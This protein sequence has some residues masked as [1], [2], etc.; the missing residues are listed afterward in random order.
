MTTNK[1]YMVVKDINPTEEIWFE[2]GWILKGVKEKNEDGFI[3]VTN[4][5]ERWYCE[6]LLHESY[7][8]E[9]TENDYQSLY[10]INCDGWDESA[11]NIYQ[12]LTNKYFEL[13]LNKEPL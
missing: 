4:E 5:L 9:M 6:D 8:Q 7:L 13:A 1:F 3:V 10:Q 12:N 2:K 11:E